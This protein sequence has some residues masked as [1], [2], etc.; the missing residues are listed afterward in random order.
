MFL[1]ASVPHWYCFLRSEFL[2]N[3]EA[4]HG[5]VTPVAVFGVTSL[6]SRAL[7][8]HVMTDRGAQVDRIPLHALCWKPDAPAQPLDVLELWDCFSYDIAV[9]EFAYLRGLRCRTILKDRR[10]Y[11]GEYLMTF[12]WAKSAYAE[13]AGEGGHKTGVLIR[14]DNGNFALQPNNRILWYEPS[15]ITRPYA[16]GERPDYRTN[17]R[18]WA[19]EGMAKWHTEDGPAFFYDLTV[20][21]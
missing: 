4:H 2:Y 6:Q 17:T 9:H 20:E 19:C 11:A 13:D 12:D 3:G 18:N 15:F 8:F 21:A 14:L 10:W 1:L 7:T 5:E 16:E